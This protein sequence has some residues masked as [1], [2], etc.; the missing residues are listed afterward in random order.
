MNDAFVSGFRIKVINRHL[1][2]S[3]KLI[4]SN[5]AKGIIYKTKY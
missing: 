5:K 4:E 2:F 1:D 3:L